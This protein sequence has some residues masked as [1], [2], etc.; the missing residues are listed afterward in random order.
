MKRLKLKQGTFGVPQYFRFEG[1]DYS[2]CSARINVW[3]DGVLLV[4]GVDCAVIKDGEDTV[5]IFDITPE[6]TIA[7]KTYYGEI[8]FYKGTQMLDP[9][10]TFYWEIVRTG[11]VL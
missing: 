7:V 9:S 6:S 5:V 11:E 8:I 10:E 3:S 2:M 1:I 4:D